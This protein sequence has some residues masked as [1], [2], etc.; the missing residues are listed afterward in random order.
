MNL[1]VE[2][3]SGN[4]ATIHD[5]FSVDGIPVNV[6]VS[7]KLAQPSDLTPGLLK[8]SKLQPLHEALAIIDSVL[9]AQTY[10]KKFLSNDSKFVFEYTVSVV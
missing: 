1:T 3:E 10:D 5:C 6:T 4:E 7:A 8:V 2:I 9:S